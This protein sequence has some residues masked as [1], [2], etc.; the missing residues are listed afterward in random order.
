M[1]ERIKNIFSNHKTLIQNFSYLS[2]LQVFNMLLPLITYPYLIRVLGTETYGRIVYAQSII[3]FIS[4]VINFGFDISATKDISQNR[5]DR[6]K[7][8]EIVSSVLLL[9]FILWLSSFIILLICLLTINKFKQDFLLYIFT[10]TLTFNEL[11]FLQSYFLGAEKMKFITIINLMARLIFLSLIFIFITEKSD[12]LLV[13]LLNGIGALGGGLIALFVIFKLDKIPFQ[14]QK[15]LVIRSYFLRSLPFF[16]SRISA[17]IVERTGVL[18]LGSFSTMT[19]VSYFD[20]A[21]KITAILKIPFNILN[22]SIYPHVARTKDM[23]FM[24]KILK[25]GFLFSLLLYVFVFI[26]AKYLILIL[27]GKELLPAVSLLRIYSLT[28]IAISITYNLGNCVLVVMGYYKEFNKSV[29][30]SSFLFLGLLLLSSIFNA[31]NIYNLATIAV[32]TEL[33]TLLYRYYYSKK[34]KII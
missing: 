23:P 10:F 28:I 22:S 15:Y 11:M 29:I 6:E 32:I 31:I 18:I 8:S 25:Q 3:A 9:K 24:K 21:Q 17:V 1:V 14:R 7:L 27:G 26:I 5:A 20:L 4:I 34:F 19:Q 13:P 12:Y 16:S 30:Y 33:F 2:A